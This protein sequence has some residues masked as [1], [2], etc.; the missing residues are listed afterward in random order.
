VGAIAVRRLGPEDVELFRALRLEALRADPDAYA[1]T[2][3]DWE[4]LDHAEWTRRLSNPVVVAFRDGLPVGMMGLV[5]HAASKMAHRAT[6]VMAYVRAED[7]RLGV[8]R[9]LLAGVIAEAR[10]MGFTQ[11]EL[12]VS[13][14][15]EAA[16]RFYRAAGFTHVGRI[17]VGF[18][19]GPGRMSDEILM[20][21]PIARAAE[22]APAGGPL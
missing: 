19:Q 13:A 8:A 10:A 20:A 14:D 1:S 3:A 18:R 17:P 22:A 21:Y 12:A 2:A 16:R 6:L 15:N 11:V 7:R 5:G 4:A 9:Q